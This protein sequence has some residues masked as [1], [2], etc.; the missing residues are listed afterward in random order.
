MKKPAIPSTQSVVDPVVASILRPMK[1]NIEIMSGVRGG[2]LATL[3]DNAALPEV[4]SKVNEII[5]RLNAHD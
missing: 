5:G 2:I 4:I 1:E 3:A